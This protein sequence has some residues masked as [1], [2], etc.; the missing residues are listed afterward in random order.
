MTVYVAKCRHNPGAGPGI[1]EPQPGVLV[2][3]CLGPSKEPVGR[4]SIDE[5]GQLV[6]TALGLNGE[7]RAH[8]TFVALHRNNGRAV[9]V[10]LAR[11]DDLTPT[12]HQGA[13]T[14]YVNRKNDSSGPA[15]HFRVQQLMDSALAGD[16]SIELAL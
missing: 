11:A 15:V 3:P 7:P 16:E 10:A 4:L 8:H 14:F 2:C 6:W 12:L 13:G 9:P 5:A 1:C